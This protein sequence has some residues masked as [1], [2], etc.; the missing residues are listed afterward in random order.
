MENVNCIICD[1]DVS[2]PFIQVSDRFGDESFQIVKCVCGFKYLSPRPEL[3]KIY[4]YYENDGYDPHRSQKKFL[5]DKVYSWVQRKGLKWF[6][7]SG[8]F[9][10]KYN[11]VCIHKQK[12]AL[13]IPI[14]RTD[15]NA[16][17]SRSE[18]QQAGHY[19]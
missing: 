18:S 11:I 6:S 14:C 2:T 16:T 17:I 5:F 8:S 12:R 15:R 13:T 4:S 3:N 10:S 1:S 19:G 7:L 9:S